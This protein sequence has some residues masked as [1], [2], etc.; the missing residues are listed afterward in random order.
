MAR[1]AGFTLESRHGGWYEEPFTEASTD[2]VS[3]Y[4]LSGSVSY[5]PALLP[6]PFIKR[7]ENA[8][9]CVRRGFDMSAF[10]P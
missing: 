3:V 1:L 4:R 9:P 2:H 7:F 5:D 10:V 6:S 8:R